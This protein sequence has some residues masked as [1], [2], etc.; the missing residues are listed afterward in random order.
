M[1]ANTKRLYWLVI[2][3][4]LAGHLAG[5]AATIGPAL[6]AGALQTL[7]ALAR[8]RHLRHLEVQVRVVFLVLLSIG[9]LPG[10]WALHLLQFVGTSALLV[11]DYCLLARLLAALPWNRTEPFSVDLLRRL[12]LAPPG[13]GPITAHLLGSSSRGRCRTG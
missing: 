13:P 1:G 12:L 5:A 7:H 11:A 4:L 6:L 10:L 2:A 3:L 9:L 8:R